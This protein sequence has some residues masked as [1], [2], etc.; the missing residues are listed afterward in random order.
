MRSLGSSPSAPRPRRVRGAALAVALGGLFLFALVPRAAA[1]GSLHEVRSMTM[2]TVGDSA[3]MV[4]HAP[5]EVRV[6]PELK[7]VLE[8][9]LC[10]CGCN[11][12]AYQCQQTMTCDVSTQMWE[13]AERMVDREGKTPEQAL[14]LFAADYGERVLA[15]PLKKGFNLTAWGLPFA[16]LGIG[17]LVLVFALRGWRPAAGEARED[18]GPEID[19]RYLDRIERELREEE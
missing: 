19:A 1:A 18:R 13:Q 9:V 8:G 6:S 3:E 12:D 15:A 2:A 4:P 7:R 11:L 14:E 10:Q 5:T 16:A 17:A